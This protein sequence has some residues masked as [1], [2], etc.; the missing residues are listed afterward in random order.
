MG[1]LTGTEIVPVILECKVTLASHRTRPTCYTRRISSWNYLNNGMHPER[2]IPICTFG[3][4]V[5][6]LTVSIL[7][8]IMM[9]AVYFLL[10]LL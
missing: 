10:S 6:T 3:Y 8:T 9:K 5:D 4:C 1:S 7:T 2:H